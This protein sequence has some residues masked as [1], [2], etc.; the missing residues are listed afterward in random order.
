MAKPR[1][2]DDLDDLENLDDPL[3]RRSPDRRNEDEL[4]LLHELAGEIDAAR[5][6]EAALEAVLERICEEAG[7]T[8]GEAWLPNDDG[9]RLD[10]RAQ[11]ATGPAP[12]AWL[13]ASEGLSLEP[14]EGLPGRACAQGQVVWAKD[15]RE[16]P[17]LPRSGTAEDAGLRAGVAI[18][19]ATEG[20]VE[21]VLRFTV[22]EPRSEDRR[23]VQ[24]V[25]TVARTL[26]AWI[27]RRR[28]E[29]VLQEQIRELESSHRELERF[30][31]AAAH[32]LQE[33]LR[34]IARYVQ[35]VED[36]LDDRLDDEER[37]YMDYAV[38][39]ARRL[40]ELLN[41]LLRYA[42][43]GDHIEGQVDEADG[44][45]ALEDVLAK[46]AEKI[47][48]TGAEITAQPLPTLSLSLRELDTLLE[49]LIDN[50]ITYHDGG[51]PHVEIEASRVGDV[52]LLTVDDDGPGIEPAYQEQVF[53]LFE[54]LDRKGPPGAGVGLALCRRIV[55]RHGGR[56]LLASQPGEGTTVA[57][58]LP[59]DGSGGDK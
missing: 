8:L 34:D 48:A 4:R 46:L 58:R 6:L 18:P 37:E 17:T 53:E 33:P 41:D 19:V 31:H 2:E 59:I 52:W 13:Q 12:E 49:E 39:G 21:A 42:E 24:M 23:F 43:A 29:E 1:D 40:H 51:T 28:V 22:D 14:D 10:L 30:A 55:E 15:L 35:L 50:A 38:D 26:A 5:D 54:R 57:A 11:V 25:S 3:L 47:E 36:R 7:F 9:T 20:T 44:E 27:H 16:D 45:A 56:L 32:D